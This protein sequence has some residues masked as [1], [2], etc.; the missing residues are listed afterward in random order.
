MRRT[1][2]KGMIKQFEIKKFYAFLN[3][4]IEE[5]NK[6]IPKSFKIN[7]KYNTILSCLFIIKYIYIVLWS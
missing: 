6:L 2:F 3:L 4:T 7:S 5:W 1:T